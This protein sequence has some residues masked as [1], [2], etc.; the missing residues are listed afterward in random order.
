MKPAP[1]Y[2]PGLRVTIKTGE[3]VLQI[4]HTASAPRLGGNFEPLTQC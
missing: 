3:R 2:Q 4:R 1:C